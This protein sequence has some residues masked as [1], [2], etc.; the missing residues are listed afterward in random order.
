MSEIR[1]SV[2]RKI[3]DLPTCS[4]VHDLLR[5]AI[6]TAYEGDTDSADRSVEKA[7]DIVHDERVLDDRF[8]AGRVLEFIDG[9]DLEEIWE[10]GNEER[11]QKEENR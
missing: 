9:L 6:D 4:R 11:R 7:I 3:D 8:R 2:L 1:N 10:E 5:D